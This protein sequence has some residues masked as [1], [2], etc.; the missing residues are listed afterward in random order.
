MKIESV[1]HVGGYVLSVTFHDGV[2][3]TIDLSDLVRVGV[4][5]TLQDQ[6]L[7]SKVF[8]TGYSLAWSED[9]EIDAN[10]IYMEITGKS[11]GELEAQNTAHA[12]N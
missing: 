11:M 5:K 9:L 4:F 12:S 8:T 2:T 1:K 6:G 10:N 7:F 3:G